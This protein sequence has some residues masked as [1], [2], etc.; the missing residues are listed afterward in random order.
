VDGS[1][2]RES[3][4]WRE[5]SGEPEGRSRSSRHAKLVMIP[6]RDHLTVLTDQRFKDEVLSFLEQE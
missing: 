3:H 5:H 1:N 2:R 4:W 6:D